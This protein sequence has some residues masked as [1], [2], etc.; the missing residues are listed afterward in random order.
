MYLYIGYKCRMQELVD[1]IVKDRIV[2]IIITQSNTNITHILSYEVVFFTLLYLW[3]L[4]FEIKTL[5]YVAYISSI[6]VWLG[7]G[8]HLIWD[9]DL[10]IKGNFIRKTPHS[11]IQ[12][13]SDT[14]SSTYQ[15]SCSEMHAIR[16]LSWALNFDIM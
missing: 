6:H 11:F 15:L 2:T 8:S 7:H 9:R 12:T 5:K 13:W 3:A 1:D 4:S 10:C 14:F 16:T